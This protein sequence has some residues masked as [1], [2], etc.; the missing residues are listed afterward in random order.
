MSNKK[1]QSQAAFFAGVQALIA[2]IQK[3]FPNGQFTFGNTVYTT[4][5]LVEILQDLVAAYPA[6]STARLNANDALTALNT[7]KANATPVIRDLVNF[8]RVT[9]RDATTQLGDFGLQAPRARP[10]MDP[11]SRLAAAAK[12]RATRAARGTVGSKKKLAIHGNV[13]GVTV[14]PNT[15]PAPA[16]SPSP[17]APA[18]A[19]ATTPASTT[20]T[21]PAVSVTK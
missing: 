13:T 10:P 20:T 17:V 4:A 3:H 7:K 11:E 2:G 12:S 1:K 8:L 5:S 21:A 19:G 15:I 9:F 16:P 6:L 18:P 14:T